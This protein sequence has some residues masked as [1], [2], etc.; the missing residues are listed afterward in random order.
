MKCLIHDC[1]EF[2]NVILTILEKEVTRMSMVVPQSGTMEISAGAANKFVRAC[3]ECLL[4]VCNQ[5]ITTKLFLKIPFTIDISVTCKTALRS[6][7]KK[8][9]II[10]SQF[11]MNDPATGCYL[12]LLFSALCILQKFTTWAGEH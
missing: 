5:L 4:I 3:L 10:G 1:F 9:E 12:I 8:E 11:S 2:G 7:K 6:K